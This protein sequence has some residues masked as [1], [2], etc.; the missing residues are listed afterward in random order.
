METF[1]QIILGCMLIGLLFLTLFCLGK[2][3]S[4]KTFQR[5]MKPG[6]WCKWVGDIDDD[7]WQIQYIIGNRVIIW[8]AFSE[9]LEIV[10]RE[11]LFV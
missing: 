3:P 11:D 6:D 5:F 4:N 10:H 8:N 1:V 7:R 2:H 9:E